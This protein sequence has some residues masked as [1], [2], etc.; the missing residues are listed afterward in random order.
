MSDS[1][2][3]P[4]RSFGFRDFGLT[5][6]AAALCALLAWT[7]FSSARDPVALT[8]SALHL[9][10]PTRGRVTLSGC[11]PQFVSTVVI[12]KVP[13]VFDLFFG[14]AERLPLVY[15]PLWAAGE[16]PPERHRVVLKVTEPFVISFL[17]ALTRAESPEAL[18]ARAQGAQ[19]KMVTANYANFESG[20]RE[21]PAGERQALEFEMGVKLAEPLY[22]LDKNDSG[23]GPPWWPVPAALLLVLVGFWVLFPR[24][25]KRAPVSPT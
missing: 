2:S 10:P 24:R 1:P 22:V 11:Q 19:A 20:V 4:R 15:V 16:P 3:R 12:R 6:G 5:F 9:A 18:E 23:A 13:S 21:L 17:E 7:F 14:G 8:C 25:A